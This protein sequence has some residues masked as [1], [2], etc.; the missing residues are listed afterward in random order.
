MADLDA[1]TTLVAPSDLPTWMNDPAMLDMLKGLGIDP[2][3]AA[4]NF[5]LWFD[6]VKE[7]ESSGGWNTYNRSSSARGPYQILK[8]DREGKGS[9]PVMLRRTIRQYKKAGVNVPKVY[10]EALKDKNRDPADL[11]EDEVRRL[12]FLDI[13]QRPQKNKE[14]VG[15]DQLLVSLAK[16]NWDA[17]QDLYLDHHHTD[18]TDQSTLKRSNEKFAE[19][20]DQVVVYQTAPTVSPEFTPRLESEL[21]AAQM[22][23][24]QPRIESELESVPSD[25]EYEPLQRRSR[26][27]AVK[28]GRLEVPDDYNFPFDKMQ[29]IELGRLEVPDALNKTQNPVEKYLESV[30]VPQ[31]KPV[32]VPPSFEPRLESELAATQMEAMQPVPT[33]DPV[34]NPLEKYLK[35]RVEAVKLGRLEISENPVEKYIAN[36]KARR[37]KYVKGLTRVA[38]QGLAL[39]FGEEAESFLTGRDVK[40]IRAEMDEFSQMNPRAALYGEIIPG[41][42]TGVNLAR[43]L[44]K[45]GIKSLPVQGAIEFGAYGVG[46]G[47][48]ASERVKQGVLFAA[49]GGA[50]GKALDIV[51]PSISEIASK[52]S[53]LR[54]T[55]REKAAVDDPNF[56]VL[57][58]PEQITEKIRELYNIYYPQIAARSQS[59]ILPEPKKVK[60]GYEYGGVFVPGTKQTGYDV[61]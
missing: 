44:G 26:V 56:T 5:D 22:E 59:K 45:A 38:G 36:K 37:A 16:G 21:A 42:G 3:E 8:K 48:T 61:P 10:L 31:R 40:E 58:T 51:I 43:G 7:I 6:T 27:E 50:L 13:Q 49:T 60:G 19:V 24:M 29:S 55:S 54:K 9:Y 14:G 57:N 47:E 4:P 52:S 53:A 15:T 30:T 23:A 2:Y 25:K 18:R 11:S 12:I 39:G 46:T 32:P 35:G 17:G 41:V 33:P 34:V 28:L 1:E 20:K